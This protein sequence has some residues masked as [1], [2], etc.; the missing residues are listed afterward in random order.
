MWNIYVKTEINGGKKN[1]NKKIYNKMRKANV[2]FVCAN[3]RENRGSIFP[4]FSPVVG[5]KS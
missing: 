5:N 4:N 3:I 1:E 2:I